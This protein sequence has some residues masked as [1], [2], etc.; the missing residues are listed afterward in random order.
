MIGTSAGT[1]R[2]VVYVVGA[3]LSAGLGFPTI[4]SL[5]VG[6]W[7][8]L[9]ARGLADELA[10]VI[11]FHHPSFNP[12]LSDTFPNIE[13]LLSEMQA[14]SQLF[15][16]SRPAT[17][18]FTSQA[19]DDR[20]QAL[21]LELAEWFHELQA[22]ALTDPPAWLSQLVQKVRSEKAQ[23]VSFNWDLALDQMLFGDELA[24]ADYALASRRKGPRLIKPH[25]S[26]N[27]YEESSG[28]PLKSSKKF[29][30]CGSGPDKVYAF[31]PYRAPTSTRRR[32]MPLIVPPVYSK[33]F[34]GELFTR[35]WQQTVSVISTA[36]EVRFLGYSLPSAD[37]HARFILRCGFHN[38][39]SGELREDGS[40]AHATGRARVTVVDP[41]TT[42]AGRIEAAVGW[43]CDYHATTIE[44]WVSSGGLTF[45]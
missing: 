26:L 6:I 8:R 37:F 15:A 41:S 9:E 34:H 38:Q 3:G 18:R 32:Y 12:A 7:P 42:A 17:G 36:S 31:R 33:E 22:S 28:R 10:D 35:L 30:L 16:S 45:G 25:G 44:D 19:L 11:R 27:W 21:L 39:E 29:R 1:K 14:N 4:G 24:R 23:V 5:L 40:R 43:P 2:Q 13:E 20:R